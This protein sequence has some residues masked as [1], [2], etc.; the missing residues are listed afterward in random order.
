MR[1]E[2]GWAFSGT[3]GLLGLLGLSACALM[4]RLPVTLKLMERHA[5]VIEQEE[6][7][8]SV[9][10]RL[11]DSMQSLRHDGADT[12]CG[13]HMQRLLA[14]YGEHMLALTDVS[15]GIN[16]RLQGSHIVFAPPVQ[17]VLES[18]LEGVEAHYGWMHARHGAEAEQKAGRSHA[19]G[20]G[21]FPLVNAFP[22]YN[23]HTVSEALLE[24]L[25]EAFGIQSAG[26][27]AHRLKAASGQGELGEAKLALMLGVEQSHRAL[28]VIGEK[29][30]FMQAEFFAHGCAVRAVYAAVP[31][32]G[33]QRKVERYT[34]IEKRVERM[35]AEQ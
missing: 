6:R 3:L 34:L 10:E 13:E 28:E 12:W 18:G 17:A 5:A 22:L 30:A 9:L 26:E 15:S 23:V 7:A 8:E 19:S 14:S 25:L 11:T 24:A 33:E 16:R 2:D 21:A 4:G 29:S 35:R 32:E 31:F 20:T 27:K 1:R